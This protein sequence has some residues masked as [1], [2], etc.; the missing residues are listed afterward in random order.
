LKFGALSIYVLLR[1]VSTEK[2][3]LIFGSWNVRKLYRA[4][5]LTTTAARKSTRCKL[6]LVGVQEF[7]WDKGGTVRAGVI[8]FFYG[9]GNEN[10]QLGT[11]LFY[12][13]D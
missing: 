13:T 10:Q 8:I 2:R 9:K 4:D 3:V 1:R 5:S 7:R 11:G 6:D 12:I